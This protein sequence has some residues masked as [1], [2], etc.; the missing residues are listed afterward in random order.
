M[1][2]THRPLT[3]AAILLALFM[4]AIEMTV[5]STAMPTGGLARSYSGLSVEHFMRQMTVQELSEEGLRSVADTIT[6][7]ARLEGL[8]AHASAVT[9]RIKRGATAGGAS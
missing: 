3:L 7:L 5:V 1:R 4:A 8:G 6:E 9:R 2:S